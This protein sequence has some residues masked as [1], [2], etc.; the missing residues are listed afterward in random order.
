MPFKCDC[1]KY[2]RW[3]YGCHYSCEAEIGEE[4][5][6]EIENKDECPYKKEEII[7]DYY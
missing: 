1:C 7:D 6:E 2:L 5:A 4:E 3:E